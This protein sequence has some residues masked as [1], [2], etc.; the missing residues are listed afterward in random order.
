MIIVADE[1]IPYVQEAF[2]SLGTVHLCAGHNITPAIVGDAD[3]LLVRSVTRVDRTLL[4]HSGIRFV[5]SA[6]I[7]T[8]HVDEAYLAEREIAFAHAPGSNAESVV[9]YVSAALFHLAVSDRR[10]LMGKTVGIIGCGNIGGRLSQRLPALGLRVM[11]NDPPLAEVAETKGRVHDFVTL[12]EVLS[13][14]DIVTVHVPLTRE[15]P[16]STHHLFDKKTFDRMKPG[17]WLINSSRGSV[18]SNAALKEAMREGQLGAAVLDVWEGEPTPDPELVSM[19]N[20]ATPH[21]AGY[22]YDGKVQGTVMLYQAMTDYF[23]L[24]REWD[25]EDVLAPGPMDHLSLEMPGKGIS[26]TEALYFCIRQ[27]YDVRSDDIGMRRLIERPAD[28][29]GPY[30]N[31]LR[32]IYPRRRTF[33]RHQFVID[34]DVPYREAVEHGLCVQTRLVKRPI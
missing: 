15:G 18:V 34:G 31:H 10:T 30:F 19:V 14:A 23:D 21:I 8:D 5:G 16:Y 9:E 25:P 1:N 7:G 26:E 27:M 17:A 20:L 33:T 12:D 6:T 11:K 3:A 28:E 29:Q 32:K 24:P 22:S 2:D 4:G 13:D